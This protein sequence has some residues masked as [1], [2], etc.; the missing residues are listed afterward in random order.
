MTRTP[1]ANK[2]LGQHF[3]T[4]NRVVDTIIELLN[5]KPDDIFVEVG[6]GPGALTQALVKR[7]KTLHAIEVDPVMV[8]HLSKTL[9]ASNL[10][11]HQAD[12]LQFP[13]E[14]LASNTRLRLAS[15]LPYNISSP[16]LLK[17]THYTSILHDILLMLQKEVAQR[18]TATTKS[19]QYGRLSVMMQFFFNLQLGPTIAAHAFHPAPKV[20]SA[21]VYLKPKV[22]VKEHIALTPVLEQVIKL[23]FSQRRKMLRNTLGTCLT[24]EQIESVGLKST[25]RAEELSLDDFI[26][27][28]QILSTLQK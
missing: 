8:S 3:L 7:C 12:V 23:A 26:A 13:F 17:M 9:P 18:I 21:L 10:I 2:A 1:K 11:V 15:N 6:P 16:F 25:A 22:L 27:L 14:N 28:A 4:D 5:P 20:D 19:K 24:N